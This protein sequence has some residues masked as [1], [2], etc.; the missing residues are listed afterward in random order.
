MTHRPLRV[1]P[2]MVEQQNLARL[3][4]AQEVD[5]CFPSPCAFQDASVSSKQKLVGAPVLPAALSSSLPLMRPVENISGVSPG[6]QL[7]QGT[8]NILPIIPKVSPERLIP[9]VEHVEAWKAL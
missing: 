2:L 4:S 7:L 6:S 9:L 5:V 1:V 3:R 8:H